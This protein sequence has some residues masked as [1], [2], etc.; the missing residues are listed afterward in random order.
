MI[1]DANVTCA[2]KEVTVP[3]LDYRVEEYLTQL[4]RILAE[5]ITD[6]LRKDA[7]R[8]ASVARALVKSPRQ[9]QMDCLFEGRVEGEITSGTLYWTCPWCAS[10]H[11]E[12]WFQEVHEVRRDRSA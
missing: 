9:A 1:V 6:E 7:L 2:T 10:D 4:E 12:T 11:E 3:L 8:R 5:P